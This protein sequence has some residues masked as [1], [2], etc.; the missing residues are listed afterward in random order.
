VCGASVGTQVT[1]LAYGVTCIIVFFGYLALIFLCL[2]Q[3]T[4]RVLL[5]SSD[6]KRDRDFEM[7]LNILSLKPPA[8]SEIFASKLW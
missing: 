5:Y 1:F 8:E 6:V 7:E 2:L 4:A 3:V